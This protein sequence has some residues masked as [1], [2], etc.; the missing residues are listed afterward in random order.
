[1]KEAHM[2]WYLD[3]LK[4]PAQRVRFAK[5]SFRKGLHPAAKY[6][7]AMTSTLLSLPFLAHILSPLPDRMHV[8]SAGAARHSPKNC[9]CAPCLG[10]L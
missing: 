3:H 4:A 8:S 2:I 1:M 9:L 7:S 6:M 5:G 10:S